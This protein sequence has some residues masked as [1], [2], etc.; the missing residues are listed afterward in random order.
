MAFRSGEE[1]VQAR[2]RELR[3]APAGI[4]LT[5]EGW[6][7]RVEGNEGDIKVAQDEEPF[8]RFSDLPRDGSRYVQTYHSNWR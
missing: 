4:D 7:A 8:D 6:A 2:L 1:A 5:A 3:E